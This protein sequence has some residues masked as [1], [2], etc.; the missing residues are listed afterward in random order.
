[1][2]QLSGVQSQVFRPLPDVLRAEA[3]VERLTTAISLG[4]LR[5]GEQL[6]VENQLTTMFGVATAT[7]RDALQTLRD[8]GIIETRRG[9]SGGT[10]I[11]GTPIAKP[12]LLHQRLVNLSMAELRD[13]SD[14]QASNGMAAVRLAHERASAHDFDRLDSIGQLVATADSPGACI[15][16]DSR[17]HIEIAVLAQSERLMQTEMRLL[18]ESVEILWS[19]LDWKADRDWAAADHRA[20]AT[21]LRSGDVNRA[22]SAVREHVSRNTY[23]LVEYRLDAMYPTGGAR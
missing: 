17:F 12:E 8:Q 10:F 14:E 15:R 22:Q 19:V 23:R 16:A 21:A 20:I 4:L 18:S 7:V 11:V 3:I 6:P 2:G 13:L 5:Q 1:M 9:R